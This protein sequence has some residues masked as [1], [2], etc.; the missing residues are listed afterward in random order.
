MPSRYEDGW[1]YTLEEIQRAYEAEYIGPEKLLKN[2]I[3]Q[4]EGKWI[5]IFKEK[6]VVVPQE[7]IDKTLENLKEILEKKTA[8]FLFRLDA[9]HFHP[10]VA[11]D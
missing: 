7:F 9:F 2:R 6:E 3:R 11:Q 5:G 8:S 10:F 4:E 1:F